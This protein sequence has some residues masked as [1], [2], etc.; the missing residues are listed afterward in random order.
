MKFAFGSES[1]DVLALRIDQTRAEVLGF[2]RVWRPCVWASSRSARAL[3]YSEGHMTRRRNIALRLSRPVLL[4]VLLLVACE[5]SPVF[6]GRAG[7]WQAVIKPGE[8]TI[9]KNLLWSG[10]ARKSDRKYLIKSYSHKTSAAVTFTFIVTRKDGSAESFTV[11]EN[12]NEH[13]NR[14]FYGGILDVQ[15]TRL[16]PEDTDQPVFIRGA[17]YTC[18]PDLPSDC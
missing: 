7:G 12:E 13:F 17:I 10:P 18:L 3:I 5:L 9:T 4:T 2:A 8:T 15:I 11:S 6:A 16:S 14:T 1:A